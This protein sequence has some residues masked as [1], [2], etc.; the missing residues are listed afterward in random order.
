MDFGTGNAEYCKFTALSL[1][2]SHKVSKKT[3]HGK[4][5]Q[6]SGDKF[7]GTTPLGKLFLHGLSCTRT[8]MFRIEHPR[9]SGKY[10]G[11][12]PNHPCSHKSYSRNWAKKEEWTGE[13]AAKSR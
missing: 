5:V 1:H 11:D 12:L 13:A 7:C 3:Y 6:S 2:L 10:I 4:S 8:F 9:A